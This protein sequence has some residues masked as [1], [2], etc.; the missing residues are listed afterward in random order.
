MDLT[1]LPPFLDGVLRELPWWNRD[2]RVGHVEPALP[3][4][5]EGDH[6]GLPPGFTEVSVPVPAVARACPSWRR[7]G[8]RASG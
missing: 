6:H 8:S 1:V 3:L 7:S 2:W 4:E 5:I